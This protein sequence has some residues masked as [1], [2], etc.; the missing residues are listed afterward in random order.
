MRGG[1]ILEVLLCEGTG[2]LLKVTSQLVAKF[3][4]YREMHGWGGKLWV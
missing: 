4:L 1:W 3:E 2:T